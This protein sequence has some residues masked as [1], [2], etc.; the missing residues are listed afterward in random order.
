MNL[1]KNKFNLLQAMRE[2]QRLVILRGLFVSMAIDTALL[3][4]S[5]RQYHKYVEVKG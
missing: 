3:P 5:V 2:A 1:I 4:V